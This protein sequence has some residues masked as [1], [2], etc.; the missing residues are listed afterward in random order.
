MLLL[1]RGRMLLWSG[2]LLLRGSR[3]LVLWSRMLRWRGTG[4]FVLL[5]LGVSRRYQSTRQ[6][7]RCQQELSK[8]R[9]PI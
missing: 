2:V 8:P 7:S 1:L 9:H 4:R 6:Q 5:F 3:P